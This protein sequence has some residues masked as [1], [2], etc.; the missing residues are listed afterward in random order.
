MRRLLSV[1]L[2]AVSLSG[3]I[4]A[5]EPEVK[6]EIDDLLRGGRLEQ[7]AAR[8]LELIQASPDDAW[9]HYA[10]GLVRRD[11]SPSRQAEA[12][13]ELRRALQLQPSLEPAAAALGE[14]LIA[15]GDGDAAESFLR[16]RLQA[17]PGEASSMRGLGTWLHADGREEEGEALL[18][19][20][21]QAAPQDALAWTGLGRARV[22][23]GDFAGAIA[24]LERA[25]RLAP[26]SAAARYNLARAYLG[27]Q[28]G[29]DAEREME[30]YE[31]L[32]AAQE[33]RERDNRRR[34]RVQQSIRLHEA[35]LASGS[36]LPLSELVDQAGLYVAGGR[37]DDGRRTLRGLISAAGEAGLDARVALAVLERSAGEDAAAR[38]LLQQAL[39]L[40]PAF[41]PALSLLVDL[42]DTPQRRRELDSRLASLAGNE[43][44]PERLLLWRGLLALRNGEHAAAETHLLSFLETSP[45][46]PDALLN[47]GT[48]YGET[49]RTLDAMRTFGHLVDLYP[50]DAAA[51]FNLS[52]SELRAGYIDS[53][54]LHLTRALDAGEETSTVLTLLA[55]IHSQKDET[56][57]AV[58]LLERSLELQPDQPEARA[59]LGRL[60]ASGN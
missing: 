33:T 9:L 26:D 43:S 37:A 42:A 60:Q 24:P 22:R 44:A 41:A 4:G 39:P 8:L 52:I 29:G 56:D 23:A 51:L 35:R 31:D 5:A 15:G 16:D 2:L 45:D 40:H 1:L 10:L 30:L 21:T 34:G 38:N 20:A 13:R 55:R 6:A 32:L 14:L 49:G 53:A 48:V 3:A 28:R 7:A 17:F 58:A 47:L 27:T 54:Q 59:L 12:T 25:V 36:S 50:E 11:G 19:R 18:L 57:Q 46:D